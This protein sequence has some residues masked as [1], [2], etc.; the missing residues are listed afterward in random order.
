MED[1]T[2]LLIN[3]KDDVIYKPDNTTEPVKVVT[4][5]LGKTGPYTERMTPAEYL[6]GEL[7]NRVER[8]RAVLR[9]MPE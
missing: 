2:F 3:A 7:T 8:L 1:V 4:F 5:R 6:A 9:S